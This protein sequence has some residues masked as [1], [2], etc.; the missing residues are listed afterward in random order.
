VLLIVLVV[1][2]CR[3]KSFGRAFEVAP[4]GS[5]GGPI[6]S[7]L[8]NMMFRRVASLLTRRASSSIGSRRQ[9]VATTDCADD[10]EWLRDDPWNPIHPW[11]SHFLN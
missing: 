5:S 10:T 3:A 4:S 11:L 2:C 1:F 9:S 7:L 6:C 8:I